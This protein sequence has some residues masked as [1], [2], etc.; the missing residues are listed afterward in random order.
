ME[1]YKIKVT[2]EYCIKQ[3]QV[4]HDIITNNL[5]SQA[6]CFHFIQTLNDSLL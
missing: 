1:L 4:R 2:L 6:Y 3:L 5:W